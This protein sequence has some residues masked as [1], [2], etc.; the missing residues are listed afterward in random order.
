MNPPLGYTRKYMQLH[1]STRQKKPT[2]PC[3][4]TVLFVTQSFSSRKAGRTASSIAGLFLLRASTERAGSSVRREQR[5][6]R[7]YFTS[8][9]VTVPLK[10]A[11]ITQAAEA[12]G[13]V[14]GGITTEGWMIH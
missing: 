5:K 14:G 4:A 9:A 7:T 1:K 11:R 10:L 13:L 3:Q 8:P 2:P 12:A 6:Q